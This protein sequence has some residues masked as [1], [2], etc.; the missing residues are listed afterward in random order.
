MP[1]IIRNDPGCFLTAMLERMESKSRMRGC[2]GMTKYTKYAALFPELVI[3]GAGKL[4]WVC[5]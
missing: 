1:A 4:K 5:G 3:A 2:F